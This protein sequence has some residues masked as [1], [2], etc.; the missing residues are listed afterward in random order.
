MMKFLNR[1]LHKLEVCDLLSNKENVWAI[2]KLKSLR[3]SW[4]P[5]EEQMDNLALFINSD[6]HAAKLYGIDSLY[7]DLKKLM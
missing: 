6:G 7:N 2:K 4:K 5:S 1:F 3:P